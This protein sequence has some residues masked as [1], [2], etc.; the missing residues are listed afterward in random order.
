MIASAAGGIAGWAHSH[1]IVPNAPKAPGT[2]SAVGTHPGGV[3]RGKIQTTFEPKP[4]DSLVAFSAGC[5]WGTEEA[6]RKIPGIVATAAGY[7]GGSTEFPTYEQAHASGH[8]ETVLVEFNPSRTPF[9]SL[10]NTFWKLHRATSSDGP[11]HEKSSHRAAIWT[12]DSDELK[13]AKASQ[14]RLE[15]QEHRTFRTRI[16]PA[17]PFYLAEEYHQQY[18]EKWGTNL[19]PI[20]P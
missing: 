18:D 17:Q 13:Q 20:D 7:M 19:C 6:F 15:I 11:G 2:P 10:L 14:R 8:T 3:A 4:G 1:A 16:Q 9:S 5:F 12:Y